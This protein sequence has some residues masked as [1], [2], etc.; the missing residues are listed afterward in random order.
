[1]RKGYLLYNLALVP[2]FAL[3]RIMGMETEGKVFDDEGRT[4][5]LPTSIHH[6]R[7]E[8]IRRGYRVEQLQVSGG[9]A[10]TVTGGMSKPSVRS[11]ARSAHSGSHRTLVT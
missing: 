2:D 11:A 5:E 1:M 7:A 8:L 9:A 3:L 4:T 10:A 6:V